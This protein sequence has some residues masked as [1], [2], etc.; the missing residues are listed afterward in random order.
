MAN[1]RFIDFPIASTVGD[2]DI[3]LIW[4][5]GLNK[6]TTKA[7]ILTGISQD[8]ASLT[9]VD[10]TGLTNGQIL[11]YNSVTSKWE[12]TDQ[13]NLDL[14]DLN[15]VTIVS[16]S[17][18]QVLVYNSSTSQ[19]ENSSGGYVPYIGAVTT[20]DLGAQQLQA[21]HT[22][23]TTNGS[24]ETLTIN[25]TSGSGKAINVTKGGNNEGLYVN[26]TS[27][28]G[29]AATIVGTLEATTLVKTGGTSA[30]F[31]KAD[32]SV[33]ST[34]YQNTAD[35]GQPNGYASLD[36]NGKVPLTQINDALIGNVNFQGLWNAST[37]TP[38]LVDPPSSGTK[39]Y[40]YIVSTGGTF[41][42]ITFEVGDW[43]ISNGTAWG[44]V[45]NTDAVSSV[46][47]RTGNVTA[48]N[49]DYNT[50]QVTE[51]G[52]LYYTDA[53]S[54]AALSFAAGSGAYN[55]GTGVIT[56][57]TN[58]NQITNGAGYITSAALGA[59]LPLTGG[60][61]TGTLQVIANI[62]LLAGGS[63][64]SF[65]RQISLGSGTA[66]NYQVKANADDF[67]LIEAGSHVFLEYDYGGSLG[68]GTIRLYNNTVSTASVTAT[69]FTRTGGTSSQFLKADGSV[70]STSYQ[71]LLTNPVT[72]TGT[73]GTI[74]V[75]TGSTTIGN[76]IIQSNSTQ[77][78]IV[79]N[80]SALLF[81]SLGSS[82]D[83][84]IQY[85][86]DFQLRIFNSRGTGSS[87]Y[88][89]STNLDF[90]TSSSGNPKL[91]ITETGNVGINSPTTNNERL[92]VRQTTDNFSSVG[93]YTS[94]STGTSYGP[95]IQAGTNS[96]DASLRVFNQ[97]GT[98][99]YLH[100]RGD[101]NV[102]IGT[103]SPTE[104]FEV[105]GL[106]GN[107]RLY[108]RSG[109]S[110]NS[111]S[112]NLYY[113]GS[114]WVR[115]NASF[116]AAEINFG[117]S[118]DS[119]IFSTN[120]AT[121]GS[122]TERMRIFN[123]G[124]VLIQS[125]GTFTN[126][127]ARL[128]VSGEGRF[129]QPLT[130]T[131]SYLTVENNRARNA[132]IRLKTTVGDYYLG[133]GIGADVNQFQ[134]FDGTAGV[135]RLVINSTGAATFSSSVTGNKFFV[136]TSG[137]SRE[138][139][140]F[141]PTGAIGQNIWIGGGGAN[142]TLGGGASSLASQNTSLGVLALT[143]NTTGGNNVG[144]GYVSLNTNTTGYQ[145]TSVGA[146]S[147]SSNSTGY[148]NSAFGF[149]SLANNT[150]GFGNA[151]FG[152]DSLRYLTTG[153]ENTAIG[154]LAGTYIN[155]GT[156]NGTSEY[157]VYVGADTRA[158]ANANTNEIV[159][160]YGARGQGSNS[161][162][163][164]NSSISKTVL[165]G[166]VL[167]GTEVDFGA[168]LTL[169]GNIYMPQGTNREIFM[170]SATA[171]NY[172]IRSTGDDF[173]INEAGSV[174]RLR[175]SYSFTRWTMTGG[176]TVT[177][178]LSKG[179]GSFKIDHPLPEKKDTHNLVHSFIEGPQ[180]DNIYRGK[181]NLLN[182][183]AEVNIDESAKMTEGTFVLLN[184]NVQ[185]FTSNESGYIAINGKVDGNILKI[186]AADL[187]C[188]DTISWLVIGERIDQH[189]KDTDWTDENGK[190]IVE[191]L[192]N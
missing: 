25:H 21:G 55:S 140:T 122:V 13:G 180:A 93:F 57:P 1:R 94:A 169:A 28:S 27:G 85:V 178:S 17:N 24:T 96:S 91:R 120:S 73:S 68:N 22:T 153:R 70:D 62:N 4:Q 18:G 5:D 106:N 23:L 116:G 165:R 159:I 173:I 129:Y 102:G 84:G 156:N 131:T 162:V 14:N 90:N 59:Y 145:N 182:G 66:Y 167:I 154:N 95:I 46:F 39:G 164:G 7:T 137:Q 80:G 54:R 99:S 6:Q 45:D 33:D 109:I 8:L 50:S 163:L 98:V 69:S 142:S 133:T 37:N 20:V 141:H 186:Q 189:M 146:F 113:N 75:F 179:S 134:I 41:A 19:W 110:N 139:S 12:N 104:R 152:T 9:D 15:D 76:S 150:T 117:S 88:L 72:G 148:I 64:S 108:G 89:G 97:A 81:D 144:I 77:V 49:G 185:C 138:I 34:T 168:S 53:R 67:Q 103:P 192:K 188:N 183:Y 155:A 47:G 157:S 86:D 126:N 151:A 63:G 79:G 31:L 43:I 112:S 160:G 118:N 127:G 130:S 65:D 132:A 52:N 71:P 143:Y 51:S 92:V 166:K 83:G 175:Y 26:K 74:P 172:R 82:K 101:G 111:I 158:S 191:P 10:L 78:N 114:A 35:K 176:L 38:T 135:N 124:N 2:N 147:M 115:D 3:I 190:V 16:P 174:D 177:G 184:G 58:N 32:G 171:Y 136:N 170:G 181:I 44:K 161:A 187:K 149:G 29:N 36:G 123:D 128:Q 30:Q 56:I 48:S 125:G 40:Y 11:R 60:T 105:A 87:I 121:S 107:I 119:I 42:G 100:V 61:L